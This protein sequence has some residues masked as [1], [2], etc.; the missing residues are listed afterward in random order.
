MEKEMHSGTAFAKIEKVT[1]TNLVELLINAKECI[2]TVT[3]NKK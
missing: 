3:F 1:R 2:F